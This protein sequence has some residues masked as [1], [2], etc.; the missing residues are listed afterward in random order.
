M[1]AEI[2]SL[3]CADAQSSVR[4]AVGVPFLLREKISP[5]LVVNCASATNL[6]LPTDALSGAAPTCHCCA[7]ELCLRESAPHN[8]DAIIRTYRY[9]IAGVHLGSPPRGGRRKTMARS[10]EEE[11]RKRKLKE[12]VHNGSLTTREQR[13]RKK[14]KN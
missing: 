4:P 9:K 8:G 10:E 1:I 2:G 13:K 14:K 3:R 6:P 5:F 11:K 7:A 12:I